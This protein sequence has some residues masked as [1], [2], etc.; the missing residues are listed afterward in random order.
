MQVLPEVGEARQ[1]AEGCGRC[2]FDAF[3]RMHNYLKGGQG[4]NVTPAEA[5]A[6]VVHDMLLDKNQWKETLWDKRRPDGT[7]RELDV[8]PRHSAAGRA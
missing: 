1:E 5:R 8:E 6:A 3:A 4:R 2:C 7:G